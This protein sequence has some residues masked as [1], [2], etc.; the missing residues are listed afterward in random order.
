MW[1]LGRIERLNKG[2]DDNIRSATI[3]LSSVQRA[4]NQLYPLEISKLLKKI[5]NYLIEWVSIY[6][7][8][9]MKD[10]SGKQLLLQEIV[11][12]SY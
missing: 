5:I 12:T 1:K 2:K 9:G 4:I 7:M 6:N 8:L 3:Y 10:R 11:S